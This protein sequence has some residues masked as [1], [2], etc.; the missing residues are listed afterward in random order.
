[1]FAIQFALPPS[2]PG[3][4]TGVSGS[5]PVAQQ[6]LPGRGVGM[7]VA[8]AGGKLTS[9]LSTMNARPA[10]LFGP[11]VAI[12]TGGSLSFNQSGGLKIDASG[13][14]AGI[15]LRGA[16]GTIYGLGI[17][18]GTGKS[19]ISGTGSVHGTAYSGALYGTF[20]IAQNG[21]IDVLAGGSRLQ[22]DSARPVTG[23]SDVAYGHRGGSQLFGQLKAGLQ[24]R[25]PRWLWSPYARLTVISGQLDAF[26]E[27][28]GIAGNALSFGRERYGST[29]VDLGLRAAYTHKTDFGIV[30]PNVRVEYHR[31]IQRSATASV[32]YT[33]LTNGPEYP[34]TLPQAGSNQMMLGLGVNVRVNGGMTAD[35]SYDTSF[36][37]GARS[38]TVRANLAF[39]F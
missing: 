29:Q 12:W 32:S 27:T 33:D 8:A 13:L 2:Q 20:R 14:S 37:S 18:Y 19:T 24:Y 28:S 11:N 3:P 21:F 35:V 38:A 15:D 10:N 36:G 23:S 6:G 26:S 7:N 31:L 4:A 39:R 22:F 34:L 5:V 16:P 1:D 30:S 25:N 9:H 17:G